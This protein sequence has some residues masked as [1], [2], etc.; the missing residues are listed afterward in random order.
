MH[1]SPSREHA[2]KV[3]LPGDERAFSAVHLQPESYIYIY[4]YIYI[5]VYI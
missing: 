4:I 2:L 3:A 5:Y 1:L